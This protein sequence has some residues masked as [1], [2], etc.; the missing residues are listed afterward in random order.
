MYRYGVFPIE[1]SNM[2]RRTFLENLI[3]GL[4]ACLSI[5]SGQESIAAEVR[6]GVAVYELKS[7]RQIQVSEV[8]SKPASFVARAGV[9]GEFTWWLPSG[10]EE[11]V[12]PISAGLLV[13]TGDAEQ[14]AWLRKGSPWGLN[15]LPAFGVRYGD[16]TLV[17]IVP[18][19]HYAELVVT[20]RVGV[21]FSFPERRNNTTPCE[22]VA[23]W[24]GPEP[25]AAAEVFR[26]WRRS[27]KD[28]GAIPRPRSLATKAR[29]L[30]HV[31]RLFGAPHLY[32]WGPAM[33]SRHDVPRNK[34]VPL[35]RALRD[36]PEGTE[37]A[38]LR[39]SFSKGQRGS[40]GEL[41]GAEWPMDYLLV[42][43]AQAIDAAMTDRDLSGLADAAGMVDVADR[44]RVLIAKA[45]APYANKAET[46]G[47][48][49][50]ITLLN[51]LH[52]A[53]LDRALLVLSDLYGKAVR[54][55]VAARAE[56]LGYLL[57]PYDSYHSVHS[58]DAQ[59]DQTWETAQ[60][61]QAA[62]ASG[63]V[64][65]AEGQGR[66]GF[67]GKGFYLAPSAA[68]PYV[69]RRVG[70]VLRSNPYSAWFVDCDATAECFDDYNPLHPATRVEDVD[71]RRQ[72]LRWL[73]S[74]KRLV[75]GSED[76]SALFADVIHFGHGVQTPYI[77]HLDPAF[78]DKE[79]PHFL[80]RHWPPDSPEVSFKAVLVPASLKSP[81]FDP[82]VRLPL[83]QAAMG[84]E[85]V[86]S[87]HW[88][89]DSFKF[90][91]VEA[92]RELMEILYMVP[93]MVHLNRETWPQ[94]KDRVMRHFAFWSPLHRQLTTAALTR[95]EWLS[96][97]RLVQRTTFRHAAGD[98]TITVNFLADTRSGFPPR[99]ATVAGPIEM[100]QRVY[101]R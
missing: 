10:A 41:A 7:E 51:E 33:F 55:D 72:R 11:Y 22:V 57:G 83:Y 94:R 4:V 69:E 64:L 70:S 14:M 24:A 46:W 99:S 44:N 81:Y 67:R 9:A 19:P 101:L 86:V 31:A 79:S 23:Q 30:P 89:F 62:Y 76:G 48:G 49:L 36:A 47:D 65:K 82:R 54:P 29:D 77:G 58:P 12:L 74:E 73:E 3:A 93:P 32:L 68:W 6:Q 85:V 43:V 50:S 42:D 95:F 37:A 53:G 98:V 60:F 21:R 63:R 2:K 97:D 1:K 52:E 8:G 13:R 40:L 35:A 59:A 25:L 38:R 80:G 66:S 26:E 96:E 88:S 84:D 17:V 92:D 16:R 15:Q 100:T 20:E 61:D 5:G 91:D 18:R 27:A 71:V 39:A 75:V 87:H 90:S 34:W 28:T 56:E 45:L 78:R